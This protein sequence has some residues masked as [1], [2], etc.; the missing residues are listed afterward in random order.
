M[1]GR[2]PGW[3]LLALALGAASPAAAQL[4]PG[5]DALLA[6]SYVF[7][8][9]TRTNGYVLQPDA[10]VGYWLKK[11]GWLTAG[12][13]GNLELERSGRHDI[14]DRP[15][16]TRGLGEWDA[17][18]QVT[19]PWGPVDLTAGWTGYFRRASL[20]AGPG[21]RYHTHELYAAVQARETYLSPRLSAWWDVDRIGGVYLEGSVSLPIMGAFRGPFWAFHLTATA[22]L[23]L[24]QDVDPDH[25]LE[26][27]NFAEDGFTHLDLGA[28]VHLPQLSR[29][30]VSTQIEGHFQINRDPLT[31]RHSR[32]AG[33]DDNFATW[34][35]GLSLS[36]PNH[37][38]EDAP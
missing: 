7:R 34:W 5:A 26:P 6:S 20:V 13:W 15:D 14:S 18:A 27:A 12:V 35:F 24:G 8:G 31:K 19:H 11:V 22:G 2:P 17:W 38:A 30:G 29:H 10:Y 23:G 25:L 37:R 16:G 9:V 36:L 32:A 1:T 28:D 4:R 33:D 3:C 21:E